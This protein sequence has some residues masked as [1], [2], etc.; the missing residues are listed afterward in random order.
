M[1][2]WG[3]RETMVE[4]QLGSANKE[5]ELATIRRVACRMS[6]ERWSWK[7]GGGRWEGGV[8]MVESLW[9]GGIQVVVTGPDRELER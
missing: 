5:C 6:M 2:F 8:P 3:F 1:A 4:G 9:C 7:V